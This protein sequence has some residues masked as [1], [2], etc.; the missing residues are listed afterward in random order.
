[1]KKILYANGDSFTFGMECLGDFDRT[2]ANRDLAFPKYISDY[3]NCEQYINNA[4]NGASNDFIF[5]RTLLDLIELEQQGVD[6]RDVFVL[7]GWSSLHRIEIDGDRWMEQIPNFMSED[8]KNDPSWPRE[9]SDFGVIFANPGS[10]IRLTVGDTVLSVDRDIIPFCAHFLWTDVVQI[11]TQ[12]TRM[13]ALHETLKSK[14]Y[15][16]VFASMCHPFLKTNYIDNYSK[17]FYNVTKS[18]F[19]DYAVVNYPTE[20]RKHNHFTTV[21]H[22]NYAKELFKYIKSN[23]IS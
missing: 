7:V 13:I 16:H 22:E 11:A 10:G 1:M 15:D 17:N 12:E 6:P 2:L 19:Y 4:Y 8:L 14:G 20:M 5:K 18:S 9:Y 23:C 3:L 21:P